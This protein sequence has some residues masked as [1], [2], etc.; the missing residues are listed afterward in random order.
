MSVHTEITDSLLRAR[1]KAGSSDRILLGKALQ[2][3]RHHHR[4]KKERRRRKKLER[5]ATQS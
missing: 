2:I 1:S 3:L 4:M 5:R